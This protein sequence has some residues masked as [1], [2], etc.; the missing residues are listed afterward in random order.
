M[1]RDPRAATLRCVLVVA[2]SACVSGVQSHPD[3]SG[4]WTLT[5]EAAAGFSKEFTITLDGPS[6][7]MDYLITYT[8]GSVRSA[9]GGA[10]V[11]TQYTIDLPVHWTFKFDGSENNNTMP[12][13]E[14][15]SSEVVSK[16]AWDGDKFVIVT[17]TNMPVR[18]NVHEARYLG[19][20]TPISTPLAL[21]LLPD[22]RS[23]PA[24][25]THKQVMWLRPDGTLIIEGLW[26]NDTGL[27][28]EISQ[29]TLP[30]ST[31]RRSGRRGSP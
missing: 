12:A 31:Y 30:T 20:V 13:P 10:P 27:S 21:L 17:T 14:G 8:G 15:R 22:E 2:P 5:S 23:I 7:R 6:L 19:D 9:R 1:T 26:V 18:R 29:P 4:K 25:Q 11:S 3:L 16:S 28:S 24:V